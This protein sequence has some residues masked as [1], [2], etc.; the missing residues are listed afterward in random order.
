MSKLFQSDIGG[1]PRVGVKWALNKDLTIAMTDSS[2]RITVESHARLHLGFV[3]LNGNLGRRFG[4][5][6][7]GLNGL[8]TRVTAEHSG[9]FYVDGD[10]SIRAKDYALRVLRGLGLPH[11]LRLSVKSS[12]PVHAGLGSGTQLALAVA[13]AI[14]ELFGLD[15]E[16][17]QRAALTGR[18]QRSGIGIGVDAAGSGSHEVSLLEGRHPFGPGR[19]RRCR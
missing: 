13:S 3:D 16:I 19:C 8:S 10:D 2:H 15:C 12:I 11:H 7:L 18:G 5:L 14:T 9:S 6:G 4:S 1:S 17:Q